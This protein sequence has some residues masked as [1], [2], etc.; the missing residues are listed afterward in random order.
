MERLVTDEDQKDPEVVERLE[1][2]DIQF[3][4]AS[5]SDSTFPQASSERATRSRTVSLAT[6]STSSIAATPIKLYTNAISVYMSKAE[7]RQ[8]KCELYS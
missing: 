2:G 3:S 6:V 4:D 5:S 7:R 1:K 8:A